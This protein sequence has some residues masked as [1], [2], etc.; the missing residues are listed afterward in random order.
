M[1]QHY[2]FKLLDVNRA[3]SVIVGLF[4][5]RVYFFV[6]QVFAQIDHGLFKLVTCDH[7]VVVVIKFLRTAKKTGQIMQKRFKK[8]QTEKDSTLLFKCKYNFLQIALIDWCTKPL[9]N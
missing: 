5:Y 9:Q 8:P 4:H 3:V 6:C 2:A 1:T 7:S